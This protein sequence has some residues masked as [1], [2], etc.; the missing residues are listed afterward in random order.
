MLIIGEIMCPFQ[1]EYVGTQC[2]F[3]FLLIFI[4]SFIYLWLRWVFVAT[5][6]L[7]LVGIKQGLLFIA[8]ASLVAEHRL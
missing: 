6:G 2:S 3:F 4:Y 7:S 8:V 5:R 1:E